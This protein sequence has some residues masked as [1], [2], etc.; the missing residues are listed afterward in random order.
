[1]GGWREAPRAWGKHDN[2]GN[3]GD[4]VESAICTH[5][6][7]ILGMNNYSLDLRRA[8]TDD[9]SKL[10]GAACLRVWRI[11]V[12]TAFRKHQSG[13]N[14]SSA[15]PHDKKLATSRDSLLLHAVSAL[16]HTVK[17]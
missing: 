10:V 12:G 1:M 7:D 9:Q 8:D 17:G 6:Y 3:T 4:E 15:E 11:A 14:G 13:L 5:M 2:A 16:L